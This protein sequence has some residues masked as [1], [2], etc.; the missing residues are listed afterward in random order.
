[1]VMRPTRDKRPQ[2]ER[3]SGRKRLYVKGFSGEPDRAFC[4]FRGCHAA[5]RFFCWKTLTAFEFEVTPL[6]VAEGISQ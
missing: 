4:T 5:P 2:T 1:M 3:R 6:R